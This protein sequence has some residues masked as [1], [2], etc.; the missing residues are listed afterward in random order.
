MIRTRKRRPRVVTARRSAYLQWHNMIRRCTNPAV[1]N[2]CRYGGRG[3]AVCDRWRSSFE[4]FY[5]DMGERP[6]PG[7]TLDRIDNDGD[8]EPANCRWATRR[9]QS[10]NKRNN[11][12][13]T[14]EGETLCLADWVAR[15]GRARESIRWRLDAGLSPKD[16]IFGAPMI[17]TNP[18]KT[19]ILPGFVD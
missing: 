3:I 7:H 10:R 11:R 18:R 14:V 12:W 1:I 4:A 8:Y 5:L 9:E 19:A 2:F 6:S 17:R 13:I 15:S 16:A